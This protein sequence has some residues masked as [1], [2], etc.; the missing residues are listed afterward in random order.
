MIK[1]ILS[2]TISRIL[3]ALISLIIVILNSRELGPEGVARIGLL[4]LN[5]SI[6]NLLS[7]YFGGAGLTYF[8]SRTSIR[9]LGKYIFI[10]PF[11]GPLLFFVV[12]ILMPPEIQKS[13]LLLPQDIIFVMVL[14][15]LLNLA[16]NLL[17]IIL[18]REKVF[19]HNIM[20]VIQ[21]MSMLIFL[22]IGFYLID[23]IETETYFFAYGISWFIVFII[24]AIW[25]VSQILKVED[26]EKTNPISFSKLAIYSFWTQSASLLQLFNYR[27]PYYF[28][29]SWVGN[30]G[31]GIFTNS[32]QIAEGLWIPS[33]S[34]A[35]VQYSK[36]AN[37]KNVKLN[38][39][40]T[41]KLLK[42]TVLLTFLF[43]LILI[44]LP[45]TIYVYLFKHPEFVE[46]KKVLIYLLPGI[47]FMVIT[48]I[49]NHFF[50]G[51]GK[52]ELNFKASLISL[53]V[54]IICSSVFIYRYGLIGASISMSI[55][56][57]AGA[58]TSLIYFYRI[59]KKI[60]W[61]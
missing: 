2:T 18:G 34:I 23:K 15:V 51:I 52:P 6:I 54:L 57:F 61:N 56:Y 7:G 33:K 9:N 60:N 59:N 43:S 58:F 27:M 37:E 53:I 38:I 20:S 24:G 4:V 36:I 40:L 48:T 17:S 26:A 22:F 8:T 42:F 12:Y 30:I 39:I 19:M 13:I 41:Q 1:K 21:F 32:N 3:G 25:Y 49:T 16:G 10:S 50:S 5:V 45:D 28:I 11:I 46:I 31:L 35:M 55:G 44:L 29:Q 47:V 14:S